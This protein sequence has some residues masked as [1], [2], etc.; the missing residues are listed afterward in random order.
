MK[1]RIRFRKYGRM[2]FI[3][4][5]DIMRY[6]QKAI[7]MSG[8]DVCYSEGFRPHQMMSFAAPLGVGLTSD[9]EYLDLEVHTSR[10]S[11]ASIAA[12]NAV[13]PEGMEV[14]GYVQLA[15]HEKT[16]MS[17]VCAADYETW[18]KQEAKVPEKMRDFAELNVLLQKFFQEPA[19]V[20]VTKKTKKSEKI[21][22]VKPLVYDFRI[23]EPQERFLFHP[24]FYLDV[25]TGSVD[26]VKPEL[27][28][29]AFFGFAQVEYDP[30]ALQIHRKDVYYM[31]AD[32]KR[33]MLLQA[34]VEIP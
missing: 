18:Y 34:G 5:L 15:D 29:E 7:R 10:S 20:L 31:D 28:L 13:M 19:Q 1:V 6:F 9:G 4:H 26:N 17:V 8:I 23:L 11:Q 25:C 32:G 22:D 3:G 21:I 12:L 14:T 2:K 24:A 16:A 30:Y 33:K 27:I